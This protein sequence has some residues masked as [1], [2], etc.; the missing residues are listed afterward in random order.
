[1]KSNKFPRMSKIEKNNQTD[2]VM[3]KTEIIKQ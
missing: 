3:Q 1:M 2:T